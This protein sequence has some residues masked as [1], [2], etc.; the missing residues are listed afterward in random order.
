MVFYVA[1]SSIMIFQARRLLTDFIEPNELVF[2]KLQSAVSDEY[3]A[4]ETSQ[5]AL[6]RL[7]VAA[8]EELENSRQAGAVIAEYSSDILCSLDA[9]LRIMELNASAE[10]IWQHPNIALIGSNIIDLAFAQDQNKLRQYFDS[11]KTLEQAGEIE[12]QMRTLN[13]QSIDVSWTAEWSNSIN[14]FYCIGKDIT[15]SKQI[16]RLRAEITAMVG[17]DLRAPVSGL[18]FFIEGLLSGEFGKI[19]EQGAARVLRCRDSVEQML[20]LIN[21]LLDAEKIES[22]ELKAEL[23]ILPVSEIVE[24]AQSLLA[25]FAEKKNLKIEAE[26]STLLVNADFDRSVQILANLLSNAI[27]FS[28]DGSTIRIMQSCQDHLVTVSVEDQGPGIAAEHWQEIFQRFKS[29]GESS[30]GSSGLGLYLAKNLAELQGGSM[31]LSSVPGKG[32][33]FWFSMKAA[34]EADLPGYLE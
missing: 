29:L 31:G 19:N 30:E 9:N 14:I 16:Q 32:S 28:P 33:R 12:C 25:A 22:G 34:S 8:I 1:I 23:K 18:S 17:H 3:I 11:A 27:K 10:K 6:S 20:R 5:L 7:A 2:A 24:T 4:A 26:E 13:G 15:E 21:Q